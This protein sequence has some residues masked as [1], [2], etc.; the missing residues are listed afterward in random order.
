MILPPLSLYIHIPWC[1]QKCPYCDFNSHGVDRLKGATDTPHEAGLPE[2]DYIKALMQDL[3]ADL[4]GV[5]DRKLTS[6]FFGGGTPSLFSPEAIEQI[7]QGVEQRIP[8]TDDIEITLEANPGTVEQARFEGYRNAG[9]NRLSIGI[10]SFDPAQLKRLGRIHGRDDA[11]RAAES[12]RNAGFSRFNLDLMH[13]L[14]NQTEAEALADMQQAIDLQPDHLSWYQLTLEPNTAFYQAPPPLPDDDTLWEI[15][16]AGQQLIATAGYHQYEVS[17]YAKTGSEARHNLNYW[18]FGDYLAI[19][20]GAHGKISWPTAGGGLEIVRTSKQRHPKQYLNAVDYISQR[21]ALEPAEL[22]VEFLMN[23]LRLKEGVD[24]SLYPQRTGQPLSSLSPE[25]KKL[26]EMGL[27]ELGTG[28]LKTT[29]EG[30]IYLNAV[31][32]TFLSSE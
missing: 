28:R 2:Q 13:G 30:F 7:L 4:A 3:D 18:Q 22:P 23:A 17:A 19:G 12:A 5:Q 29:D 8:F 11:I 27:M 25:L 16:Q 32:E 20:A 21:T 15:Q 9:V 26:Q 14:P 6:I 10:Q 31:L 24:E 1:V